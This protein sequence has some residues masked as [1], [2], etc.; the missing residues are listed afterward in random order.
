MNKLRKVLLVV[1]LIGTV[2]VAQDLVSIIH[3]TVTKVDKA[4]KTVW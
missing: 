4:T 3:G 2:G 1:A